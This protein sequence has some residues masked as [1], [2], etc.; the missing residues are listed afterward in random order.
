MLI[1]SAIPF[2]KTGMK[3][4]AILGL[5][6]HCFGLSSFFGCL[7]PLYFKWC[8]DGFSVV[9]HQTILLKLMGV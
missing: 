1:I 4:A 6:H 8:F 7:L 2:T 5:E 9:I 3:L